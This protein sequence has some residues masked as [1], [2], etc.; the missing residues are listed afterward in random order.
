MRRTI[1]GQL[2]ALALTAV[3]VAPALAE[4][5]LFDDLGS[6]HREAAT[7]SKQAQR[8]FDQGMVLYFGFNHGEAMGSFRAATELDPDCAIAYWG[9]ALSVGPNINNPWMDEGR[10]YG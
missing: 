2:M 7:Q 6:F 1:V 4:A 3:I 8:Y 10:N 9:I 5:P